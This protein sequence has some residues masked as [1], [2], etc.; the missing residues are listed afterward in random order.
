MDKFERLED[1]VQALADGLKHNV[2][3]VNAIIEQLTGRETQLGMLQ[4]AI[5]AG[6]NA[7]SVQVRSMRK[8][9][10]DMQLT[11]LNLQSQVANLAQRLDEI[12]H[13]KL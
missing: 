8:S 1:K 4:D 5:R 3:Y 10:G 12:Q 11:M 9:F 2:E 7:E 13:G 6:I